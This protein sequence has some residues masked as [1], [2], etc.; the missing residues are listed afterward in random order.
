[1]DSIPLVLVGRPLI[2]LFKICIFR[3]ANVWGRSEV[4]DWYGSFSCES[5]WIHRV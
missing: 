3:I 2:F 4:Y 5:H 1:M